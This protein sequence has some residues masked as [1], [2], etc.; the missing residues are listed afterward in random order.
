MAPQRRGRWRSNLE[1]TNTHFTT[2]ITQ[3]LN[4]KTHKAEGILEGESLLHGVL[5]VDGRHDNV[6]GSV[7]AA[8]GRMYLFGLHYFFCILTMAKKQKKRHSF[9]RRRNTS[10]SRLTS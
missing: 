3:Q 4:V 7:T 1:R 8:P 10:G 5:V 2:K 6:V 9:G